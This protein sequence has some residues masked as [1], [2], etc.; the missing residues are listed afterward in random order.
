MLDDIE[1]SVEK[2]TDITD[3][4][5]RTVNL[6]SQPTHLAV[7]CDCTLLCVVAEKESCP[8]AFIYDVISF[9]AEVTFSWFFEKYVY[10]KF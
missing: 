3:Y 2:K 5:R 8:T 1:R 4:L 7:N 10:I 9:A 6:P